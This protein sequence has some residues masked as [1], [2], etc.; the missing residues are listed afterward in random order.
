M[1]RPVEEIAH[2]RED[3]PGRARPGGDRKALEAR[4]RVRAA[5][6]PLGRR[7]SRERGGGGRGRKLGAVTRAEYAKGP[8]PRREK[9]RSAPLPGLQDCVLSVR[10]SA[11]AAIAP[12]HVTRRRELPGRMNRQYVAKRRAEAGSV[13]KMRVSVVRRQRAVG[14]GLDAEIH[15][16]LSHSPVRR[17]A[18]NGGRSRRDRPGPRAARLAG[19]TT[20]VP[21]TI[22][23][24]GSSDRITKPD[25]VATSRIGT[26]EGGFRMLSWSCSTGG[27]G[28]GST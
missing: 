1:E 12:S 25:R 8:R 9:R 18:R 2:V 14:A 10:L 11:R 26:S 28:S 23:R 4:G 15:R 17:A 6:C 19:A 22:S 20:S 21:S 27:A 13:A 5:P 3:L 24:P 7:A 16:R